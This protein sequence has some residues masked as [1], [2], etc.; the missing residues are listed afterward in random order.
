MQRPVRQSS[1]LDDYTWAHQPSVS[2]LGWDGRLHNREELSWRLDTRLSGDTGDEA[3]ARVAY[4]RWG[5]H[6]LGELVGDWSVVIGDDRSR[7]IVLASDF[8]G[9]RPLHYARQG[10]TVLWSHDVEAL[11]ARLG[12]GDILD[13]TYVAAFMMWGACPGRT[14]Y[15]GIETVVPGQAVKIGAKGRTRHY[16]WRPPV[17]DVVEYADERRYDEQLRALFRDAVAVRMQ[18][19]A[20]VVA[21]LSG[22]L[23]SSSVVG[24][25]HELIR[26]GAVRTPRLHTVSYLHRTSDDR[27]FIE[28][29]EA[30]YAIDGVHIATEDH[31]LVSETG[32]GDEAMPAG[33][34]SLH[35]AAADVARRVSARAFLTGQNGDLIMGNWRDDSLQVAGALRRGRLWRASRES[36]AWSRVLR[37][38]AASVLRHGVGAL[39]PAALAPIGTYAAERHWIP[40]NADTSLVPEFLERIGMD[41]PMRLF[42][43]DWKNAPPERRK[44]FLALTVARELLTFRRPEP[45]LEFDYTHPFTH[46]PLVEFLLSLPAH[47]LCRPGEPRR[48]MRRALQDLWPSGLKTRR[49]KSLFAAPW[50]YALRPLAHR[51]LQ[52]SRWHV[53]ERGWVNRASLRTRLERL[54]HGLEC[55]EPQLRQI[56]LLEHWLRHRAEDRS[57]ETMP[58]AV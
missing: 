53:V 50:F 1:L 10:D 14:P 56:I 55:N 12:D 36:I 51:L 54:T 17:D 15:P 57:G 7:S 2:V 20:P 38:P 58:R 21:E 52:A 29:A 44:H 3:L 6:G 41:N 4:E 40:T 26:T 8:A 39:L 24:M 28:E 25:A 31:P 11:A 35:A 49:S 37:V 13:E 19:D 30:A 47:V 27:R 32:I 48:L 45:L 9:A 33:W 5:I 43:D 16:L 18:G 46:R 23:D 34:V 42:S 22:G